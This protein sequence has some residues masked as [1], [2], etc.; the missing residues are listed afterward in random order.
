MFSIISVIAH[1]ARHGEFNQRANQRV[2]TSMIVYSMKSI[3]LV[4]LFLLHLK[5][6]IEVF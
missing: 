5:L 6:Q 1:R 4:I 3:A 2:N